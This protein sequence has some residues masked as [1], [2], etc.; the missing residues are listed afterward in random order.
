MTRISVA[1]GVAVIAAVVISAGCGNGSEEQVTK[2]ASPAAGAAQAGTQALD[3]T[4]KTDPDPVR[5]GDNT[6]E[7]MVMQGGTPV[8]DAMV[9]TEF[10]MAAMPSMNMP[11]MRTKID[12]TPAGNGMYRGNGQVAMAGQWDVTVMVMRSGQEIGSKKI[13]LTAK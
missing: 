10:F 12:L 13:T 4:L 3:I 5:T 7:V 11:V 8:T 2:R 6:F 9:T 1:V